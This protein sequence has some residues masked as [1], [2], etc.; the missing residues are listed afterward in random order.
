MRY[1][2]DKREAIEE[3]EGCVEGVKE[4]DSFMVALWVREGDRVMLKKVSWGFPTVD[5]LKALSLLANLLDGE[6]RMGGCL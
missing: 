2:T 1:L 4:A 6:A 5:F 3:L